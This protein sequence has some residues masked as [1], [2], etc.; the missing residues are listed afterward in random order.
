MAMLNNQRVDN[1]LSHCNHGDIAPEMELVG[2]R[3]SYI[4]TGIPVVFPLQFWPF[5]SYNWL[6]QWNYTIYKWGFVSTYN[7]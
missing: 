1:V 7:W 3:G 4:H 5:I 2:D 6:F